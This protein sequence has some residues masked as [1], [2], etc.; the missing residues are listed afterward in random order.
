MTILLDETDIKRLEKKVFST[1]KEHIDREIK[2]EL[3]K[4]LLAKKKELEKNQ[5]SFI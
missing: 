2:S 4:I 3:K 5:L 1:I